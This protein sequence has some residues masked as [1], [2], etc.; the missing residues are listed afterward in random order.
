MTQ[1]DTPATGRKA[2]AGGE[3]PA[4]VDRGVLVFGPRK[5][6]TTLLQNLLDG[7]DWI[8]VYPHELKLKKIARSE[9]LRTSA[10]AYRDISWIPKVDSPRF[11]VERYRE[12]WADPPGLEGIADFVR[13]DA[14]AVWQ[15]CAHPPAEPLMWVAK[16]PG[17][18]GEEVI[19]LWRRIF[20]EGRILLLTREPMMAVRAV[21][22]DRRRKGV[23]PSL[24]EVAEETRQAMRV[25]ASQARLVGEPDV[26]ALAYEDLVADT[27]R[28][29]AG[30]ARF[31]GVPSAP[32][33]ATPTAFGEPVV[34]RTA[35]RASTGVF[36]SA[37]SWREGLSWREILTVSAVRALAS[38][39]PRFRVD[40]AALR[41]RIS[42]ADDRAED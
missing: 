18:R 20:P 19:G 31:L 16:E 34:V 7:S 13:F 11:S 39:Q 36:R 22:N 10:A 21:L 33:F 8:L 23:R 4:W 26:H 6:G 15:S 40:Y 28:V 2:D 35:S 37:A 25:A 30:V 17:P 12:L 24:G 38:L 32:V 27:G 3:L 5:G 29:M 1:R 14:W 42:P 9:E 41:R